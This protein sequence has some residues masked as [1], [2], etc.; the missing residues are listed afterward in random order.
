MFKNR[1]KEFLTTFLR[2]I[3]VFGILITL[4]W[5]MT[6]FLPIDLIFGVTR[7]YAPYIIVSLFGLLIIYK[8]IKFIYWLIIEPIKEHRKNMV[9]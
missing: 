6:T 2:V 5:F 4:A 7:K 3:V 9:K 1:L 8:I